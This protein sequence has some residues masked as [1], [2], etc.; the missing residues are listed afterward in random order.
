MK[1]KKIV[2]EIIIR[3]AIFLTIVIG[4][5]MLIHFKGKMGTFHGKSVKTYEKYVTNGVRYNDLPDNVQKFRYYCMGLG[6]GA[7]SVV[8]FTLDEKDYDEYVAMV[9]E[10]DQ[11]DDKYQFIG[12]KASYTFDYCDERGHYVGVIRDGVKYVIDDKIDDY[13]IIYYKIDGLY[14][15]YRSGILVN[16]DTRRIVVFSLASD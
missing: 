6:R 5:V 3:L 15:N 8:A 2:V 16:P 12:K 4:L 10:M 9:E 14:S 11:G 7:T 1:K 13:C